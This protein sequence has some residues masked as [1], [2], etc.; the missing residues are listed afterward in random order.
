MEWRA[1]PPITP[2][3]TG[4]P[5]LTIPISITLLLWATRF[6]WS[7]GMFLQ[8]LAGLE[9][10]S[11]SGL[12]LDGTMVIGTTTLGTG[13]T[14]IIT[15]TTVTILGTTTPTGGV[16]TMDIGLET[17][18]IISQTTPTMVEG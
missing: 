7:L 12:V 2:T 10:V 16:G 15:I 18:Q 11:A 17:T 9:Q 1:G 5:K 4:M 3:T 8:C 14:R 6:G 13:I